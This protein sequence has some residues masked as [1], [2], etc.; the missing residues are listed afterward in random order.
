MKKSR[1]PLFFFMA[2]K[3]L[4]EGLFSKRYLFG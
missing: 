4:A 1:D 3:A 2:K